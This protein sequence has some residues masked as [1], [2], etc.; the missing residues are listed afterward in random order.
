MLLG[1][2]GAAAASRL[3]NEACA[4]MAL[5]AQQGGTTDIGRFDYYIK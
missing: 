5:N 2:S 1:F 4:K 3:F